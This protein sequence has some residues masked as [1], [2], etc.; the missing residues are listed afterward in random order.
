MGSRHVAGRELGR[1]GPGDGRLHVLEVVR[2]VEETERR[3]SIHPLGHGV[4]PAE[5]LRVRIVGRVVVVEEVADVF[6][7]EAE[8]AR[9][10]VAVVDH[11]RVAEVRQALDVRLEARVADARRAEVMQL[12]LR[13]G[14]FVARCAEQSV[15]RPPPSEWPV[16]NNLRSGCRSTMWARFASTPGIASKNALRYPQ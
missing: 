3:K 13:S 7:V 10:D 11:A 6:V 14:Y 1:L 8:H 12:T 16:T 2:G 9:H 4:T 5:L 15:A